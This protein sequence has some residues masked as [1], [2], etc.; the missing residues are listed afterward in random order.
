MF[1]PR[2]CPNFTKINVLYLFRILRVS[3][4]NASVSTHHSYPDL[5]KEK[6]KQCESLNNDSTYA[7]REQ[8]MSRCGQWMQAIGPDGALLPQS[9]YDQT[10]TMSRYLRCNDFMEVL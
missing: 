10:K 2:L 3:N 9:F 8:L 1:I 5:K 7:S 4:V 6:Q